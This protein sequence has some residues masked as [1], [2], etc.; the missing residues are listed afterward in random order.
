MRCGWGRW[1]RR[2]R[3]CGS[4]AQRT[5]RVPR[6]GSTSLNVPAGRD[7]SEDGIIGWSKEH[8]MSALPLLDMYLAIAREPGA[9][10]APSREH[11]RQVAERLVESALSE[12]RHLDQLDTAVSPAEAPGTGARA[13]A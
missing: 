4:W 10:S 13:A 5:Q 8:Q 11:L 7:A 3:W 2:G 1:C 6:P 12:H 9:A